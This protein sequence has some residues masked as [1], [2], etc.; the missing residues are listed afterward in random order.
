R[1]AP[2]CVPPRLSLR[3]D[4]P[5]RLP[6]PL[7]LHDALPIYCCRSFA[8]RMIPG[9]RGAIVTIGSINSAQP[10]PI[11]AYNMGKAAVARLTQLLARSE[12]H[13]SELQSR[14]NLVCRRLLAKKKHRQRPHR[15]A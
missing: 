14:E 9:K 13:T 6:A 7:P 5:P 4:P 12:E 10:L 8:R 15:P 1:R 2:L 3:L 11:P